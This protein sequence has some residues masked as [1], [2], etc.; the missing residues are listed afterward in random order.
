M[1]SHESKKV[2]DYSRNDESGK[3][4]SINGPTKSRPGFSKI[5][6]EEEPSPS[7]LALRIE[8]SKKRL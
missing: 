1:H 5:K 4:A 3:G 7:S 6:K 2:Y 8:A